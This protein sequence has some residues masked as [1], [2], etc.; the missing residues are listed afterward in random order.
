MGRINYENKVGI[1]PKTIR[2]NQVWDDDMNELKAAINDNYRF[3]GE[4][5]VYTLSG[6]R[7]TLQVGDKFSGWDGDRFVAGKIIALPVSIPA[8][9]NDNTKIKLAVDSGLGL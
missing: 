1:I 2:K 8:D 5:F 3:I 9:I 7:T 6:G 4:I